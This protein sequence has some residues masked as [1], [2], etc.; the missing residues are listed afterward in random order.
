MLFQRHNKAREAMPDQELIAQYRGSGDTAFV[1]VLFER[2]SV[3]IYAICRKYFNR[4]EDAAKDAAMEVFEYLLTEL[5]K[6][7][8][9][10]FKSWLA[11]AT[12]NFCL[13]RL[14]KNKTVEGREE[15]F[16][17]NEIGLMESGQD[18]HPEAEATEKELELQRL[19]LALG[20]LNA[21]QKTCI[22]L[23]FLQGKS[24]DEVCELTG[25]D[26]NQVKS[27]IQNGKRN[28]KIRMT[29]GN[30]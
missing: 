27:Y 3:Q 10:N 18:L 12:S 8:I 2:Y 24:Y 4:D 11:R 23:F 30:E 26:Y 28:L 22:E 21:E 29:Q 25:F 19:E 6:Y 14:R 16:K 13:M 9:Q 7:E 5:K 1:G 20:H 15:E 17:K